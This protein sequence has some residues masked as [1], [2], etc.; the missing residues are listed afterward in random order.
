M[1]LNE[2]NISKGGSVSGELQ[3]SFTSQSTQCVKLHI[4]SLSPKG[5]FRLKSTHQSASKPF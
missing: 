1:K 2:D 4:S 3:N 5:T